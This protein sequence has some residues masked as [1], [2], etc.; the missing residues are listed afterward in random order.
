MTN[1]IRCVKYIT[2]FFLLVTGQ[3]CFSQPSGFKYKIAIIGNPANPDIRYDDAQL[4][5]LKNL[6]FNTIQLNIAWGA[7]PADEPLN[8]EDILYVPGIGDKERVDKR[9]SDIKFR[10]KTAKAWGFRT[11]FHFGAP[12]LDSLYKSLRPDLIDVATE[13][14]SISKPEVVK[15]YVDLLRRLKKE[16]PELDDIQLYTFDQEAWIA[17]EFGDG[18]TDR[19]IPLS[20]RLPG[21]LQ[22]L[23]STWAEVSPGGILWWEPWEISAGQIYTCIPLLPKKNFGFFLHSNIA[24]VQLTRPVDVWFKNMVRLLAARNI[25]VVGELFLSSANE[26]VEPLDRI[27]APRLV[28]EELDAMAQF[29][30]LGGVKE[31]YGTIPDRYD[32]N[33]QM[34]GIKFA[35]PLKSNNEALLELA[36]P[37]GNNRERI[38]AAW[39]TTAMGLSLFPWD[40]TWRFRSLPKNVADIQVFHKWDIAHIMGEVAP[41]PSWKSTRRSLF[42][43]TENEVLDPWFFEDVGLR[44]TSSSAKLQEAID[45]FEKIDT[46]MGSGSPYKNYVVETISDLKILEQ[47]VTAIRCYCLEANL[48]WLMRKYTQEGRAIPAKIITRFEDIMQI[49]IANQKKGYVANGYNQPAAEEMLVLFR[50]NPALWTS[51]YLIFK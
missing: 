38:L 36:K 43:V 48:A 35:N 47:I 46:D 17:N 4:T 20:E 49:D 5:A 18:P 39:E 13:K 51:K 50:Q 21:F 6:G 3:F 45:I 40:A 34:A 33:L 7:R 31:Y 23:T 25:P 19:G 15:K 44:C 11:L 29:E 41:S 28:A 22:V 30:S 1:K 8:L 37:Y 12:R 32:P 24:E 2:I 27:A 42:M 14:Y 26:E 9:L 16:V 10:A